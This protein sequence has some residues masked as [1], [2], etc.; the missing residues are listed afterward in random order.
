M[1]LG[2][3]H[4]NGFKLSLPL[5]VYLCVPVGKRGM[6]RVEISLDRQTVSGSN[7]NKKSGIEL[8][9]LMI[10]TRLNLNIPR[11]GKVWQYIHVSAVFFFF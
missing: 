10:A 3:V 9:Y 5:S 4:S 1:C 6:E 2:E 8:T 11:G 7:N